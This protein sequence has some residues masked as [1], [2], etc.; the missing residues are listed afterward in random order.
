MT[1]VIDFDLSDS[2]SVIDSPAARGLGAGIWLIVC[3]GLF[4]LG[5]MLVLGVLQ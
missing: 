5:L 1:E 2:V 4:L 3:A